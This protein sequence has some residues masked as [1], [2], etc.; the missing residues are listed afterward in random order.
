MM[1]NPKVEHE[2]YEP[3]A[4]TKVKEIKLQNGKHTV[5]VQSLHNDSEIQTFEVSYCAVLIGSSPDLQLLNTIKTVQSSKEQI[6]AD[7]I[8]LQNENIVL[9]TLKRLNL[10]LKLFCEKCRNFKLCSGLSKQNLVNSLVEESS[11]LK[12]NEIDEP[13]NLC[14]DV[15]KNVLA[16]NKF[17]NELLSLK[18]IFAMGPLVGDHFVRFISGGSLLICAAI[19]KEI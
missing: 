1:R 17:S 14:E 3:H 7:Q 18:G 11:D 6:A 16:V 13:S 4:E 10:S 15:K 19:L 12:F 5:I 2:F 9:K 8:I